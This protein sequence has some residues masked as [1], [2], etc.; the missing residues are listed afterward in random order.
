MMRKLK[1]RFIIF[2][3]T[4]VTCLLIFIVLPIN[5]LNLVMLERQSDMELNI[6]AESEG[7]FN[8]MDFNRP[9]P[10]SGPMDMDRMRSSRFFIVRSDANG[11]I[12]DVNYR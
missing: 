6:L 2:T 3:M 1:K 10:F 11:D 7:A 8:K 12:T 5:V 9:P 4:T